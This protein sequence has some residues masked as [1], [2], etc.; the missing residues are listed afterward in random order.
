MKTKDR[1][2]ALMKMIRADLSVEIESNADVACSVRAGDRLNL[3]VHYKARLLFLPPYARVGS[4]REQAGASLLQR[5]LEV[6]RVWKVSR[7]AIRSWINR[8]A[9]CRLVELET[10]DSNRPIACPMNLVDVALEGRRSI[11]S[12]DDEPGRR[13]SPL[14]D[15]SP[16]GA[17][18][19]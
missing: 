17:M 12:S 6:N 19:T 7:G 9:L 2:Y 5:L 14:L 15:S 18:A 8:Q 3:S 11:E 4:L 1:V 10:L 13:Q 16:V